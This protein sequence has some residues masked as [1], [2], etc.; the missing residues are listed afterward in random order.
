MYHNVD[1]P[2]RL[3]PVVTPMQF[4]KWMPAKDTEFVDTLRG[5]DKTIFQTTFSNM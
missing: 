2:I 3:H 4:V 5:L 1:V